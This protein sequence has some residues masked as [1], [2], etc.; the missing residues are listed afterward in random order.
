VVVR[1]SAT[2]L[3]K[4]L[5]KVKVFSEFLVKCGKPGVCKAPEDDA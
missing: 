5:K 1:T 3:M 2:V 4:K